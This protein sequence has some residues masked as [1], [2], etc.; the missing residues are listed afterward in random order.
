MTEHTMEGH[1]AT[2]GQS[3]LELGAAI[4]L[5]HIAKELG[6]SDDIRDERS[7]EALRPAY[8]ESG[9]AWCPICEAAWLK[10]RAEQELCEHQRRSVT[11]SDWHYVE[12]SECG[13]ILEVIRSPRGQRLP[14]G[15]S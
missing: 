7:G 5:A 2:D 11:T 8:R 12:C 1:Y 15:R 14:K 9:T 10:M 6:R 4:H 3:N 13:K